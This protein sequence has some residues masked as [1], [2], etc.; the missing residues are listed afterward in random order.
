M[1]RVD[2]HNDPCVPSLTM[3]GRLVGAFAEDAKTTVLRCVV[4]PKVVNLTEVTF[5][6]REGETVLLWLA[7]T[8]AE[9]I[10]E[11]SYALD[12]CERLRLPLFKANGA[13][14]KARKGARVR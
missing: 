8:G 2:I 4:P 14:A 3:E 1:L 6:D 13:G 11:S 10:A 7:G 12:L 9:F 5:A